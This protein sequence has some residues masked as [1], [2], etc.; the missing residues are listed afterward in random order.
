M[1]TAGEELWLDIKGG[2]GWLKHDQEF[3]QEAESAGLCYRAVGRGPADDAP[4][5]GVRY[6]LAVEFSHVSAHAFPV[7]SVIRVVVLDVRHVAV[8]S[9]FEGAAGEAGVVLGGA[10]V[11][12][13]DLGSVDDGL[14]L[15][16]RCF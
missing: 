14:K 16:F 6:F 4:G 9:R 13:G 1:Q 11:L 7:G 2:S 3:L 12:P 8:P 5:D 15:E 10:R